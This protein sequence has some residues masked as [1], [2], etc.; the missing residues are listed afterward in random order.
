MNVKRAG[1]VH[2]PGVRRAGNALAAVERAGLPP[3]AVVVAQ[4]SGQPPTMPPC[5]GHILWNSELKRTLSRSIL[6]SLL[7]VTARYAMDVDVMVGTRQAAQAGID[8]CSRTVTIYP[9]QTTSFMGLSMVG[10]LGRVA[11]SLRVELTVCRQWALPSR[12][13]GLLH[14]SKQGRISVVM[15]DYVWA[16]NVAR[17]DGSF[18]TEG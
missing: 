18:C 6:L 12:G 2:G 1:R 16:P 10:S 5:S 15:L 11:S 14:L 9:F 17:V 4:V 3:V 7:P 13:M 8:D